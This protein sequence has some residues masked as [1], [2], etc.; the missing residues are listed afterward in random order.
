MNYT[1]QNRIN[2]LYGPAFEHDAC[3]VGFVA[4]LAGGQPKEILP[5][6]LKALAR[7]AH[8]GAVDADGKTGDGAGVTTQIPYAVL[9]GELE[10][11]GI[12]VTSTRD[13]A[14][15]LVFLPIDPGTRRSCKD[16]VADTLTREGLRF[17]G[18]RKVPVREEILGNK[19]RASLPAIFHLLVGRP[20]AVSH[21]EFERKLFLARKVMERR[22][23]SLSVDEFY[24]ASLSHRTLVYKALLRGVDL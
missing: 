5:L 15:G 23:G 8:R 24:V 18:W 7:M 22:L 12:H 3:G 4:D 1:T 11:I 21:E 2:G 10:Q 9:D 14:V 20:Y 16:I 19:A 13:L 17:L 6:A